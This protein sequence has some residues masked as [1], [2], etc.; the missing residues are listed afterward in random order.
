MNKNNPICEM[1]NIKYPIFQGGMAWIADCHLASA[2]SNAGGL[3]LIAAMNSDGENLRKQIREAKKLTNKPFGVNLMLM[4]PY[5]EEA[6]DVVCEEKVPIVTTGAGNPAPFMEKLKNAG[7]KVIPVVASVTLAKMVEKM[8]AS[9]VIAEGC[10]SGGHVGETTT[11]ALVPQVV[12]AINIPVIAAGGIADGRGMAASFM[13]GAKGI[14]MGTAFLVSKECMV[15]K[16]YKEKILKA[17]DRDT[18][19]TGKTLGHPVRSIKNSF[20][21]DF[22]TKEIDGHTTK[23]ELENMGK[24][25]LYRAAIEGDIKTGSCMCGQICGMVKKEETCKEIIDKIVLKADTLLKR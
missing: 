10:E 22:Y 14:Q 16:N 24:G 18:I 11:M 4:S 13:L 23:D 21:R 12:D 9:A 1:L 8:G 6:V 2:V 17:K 19:V 20:S 5:I 3:G 25:S 15:H 7:V